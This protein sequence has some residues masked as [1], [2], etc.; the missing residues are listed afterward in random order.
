[1]KFSKPMHENMF[2]IIRY[3]CFSN[4]NTVSTNY[5]KKVKLI[6]SKF[7]CIIADPINRGNIHTTKKKKDIFNA[8]IQ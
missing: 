1:M 3:K 5:N 7:K 4:Q 8:C 6:V 2:T